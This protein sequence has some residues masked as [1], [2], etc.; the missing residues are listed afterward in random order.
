MILPD[1]FDL[2]ELEE[3]IISENTMP[4]VEVYDAN[5]QLIYT[6]S[7]MQWEEGQNK[8]TTAIKRKA[9]LLFELGST[10]VYK[11]F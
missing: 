3:E 9:E 11:V 4:N 1:E 10:T 7:Q 6:G 2:S 8:A 5:D